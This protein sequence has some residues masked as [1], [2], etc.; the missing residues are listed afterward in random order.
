[1]SELN[2]HCGYAAIAGRPNVGKSTLLNRIIGMKLAITSHKA[3]TTRHSILGI[4]TLE[5]GQL[6]YVDT[7]GIHERADHAMNRY[8]NRTAKTVVVDVDVV[9]FV[10]EALRWTREDAKVLG[11]LQERTMPVIL[12]V[13]KVDQVNQKEALLPFLAEMAERYDF[14]EII[15]ISASN[16]HNVDALEKLVLERLPLADNFYPEEQLTDRPEKFFAAE[17]VREQITRRYAKELPYAVSVEIERFEEKGG[18]YRINAVI[19]VEKPGQKAIIIGKQGGALKIVASQARKA[20]EQ[21][22][23][24]KVYLEVWV[25]VKKSWSDDEASLARLGYSD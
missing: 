5:Q 14:A 6:I 16:G 2:N 9:I 20:M 1:M 3:Q 7:P 19:W 10:V 18:I 25:K 24:C 8:L 22:F 13:N 23:G 12:A 21:F 17:M 4:K 11:L 15:P